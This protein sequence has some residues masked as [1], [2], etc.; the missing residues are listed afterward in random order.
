[1]SCFELIANDTT[2]VIAI[3]TSQARLASRLTSPNLGLYQNTSSRARPTLSLSRNRLATFGEASR[4]HRLGS[5][6]ST[7][8]PPVLQGFYSRI[9]IQRRD[10]TFLKTLAPADVLFVGRFTF[11]SRMPSGF[12][13][14][15]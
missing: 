13:R 15:S 9:T 3:L 4:I 11:P 2:T 10:L 14:P 5:T 8:G 7:Q 6:S 12:V 1:M